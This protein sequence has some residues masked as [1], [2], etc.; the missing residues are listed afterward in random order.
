[1]SNL[2]LLE[3]T[4]KIIHKENFL[5][6]WKGSPPIQHLL[7]AISSILAEEYVTIAKQNPEVFLGQGK[8]K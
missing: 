4:K 5:F 3:T 2:M 7:D 6:S 8:I 1:M